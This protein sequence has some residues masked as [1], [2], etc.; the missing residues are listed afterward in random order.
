MINNNNNNNNRSIG[1]ID[2]GIGG[3]SVVKELQ[4]LLPYENIIYF[5]DNKNVPYGN[6]TVGE[7]T[8]LTKRMIDFLISK[9]VK[10]IAIACN[11]I[12]SIIELFSMDYD[13]KI[14]G[15]INPVIDTI[16]KSTD[17]DAVG[18]IA[19]CF[20]V[21]THCYNKALLKV[22]SKINIISEGS[23]ELAE[24][25]DSSDY[26]SE[27]VK[28]V[29]KNH[30]ASILTKENV[31]TIILGCT[32]Y[33]LIMDIFKECYPNINFINPALQ[34]CAELN[35]YLLEN[36][37]INNDKTN[38]SFEIYTTGDIKKYEKGV[39]LLSLKKPDNIIRYIEEN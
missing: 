9:D 15:I 33:P 22:N 11:T 13:I 2:S 29:V 18:L 14:I 3:L 30:I 36:N 25:I 17:K 10:V 32:H 19:T 8:S 39:D 35:Q 6:K 24:I 12:S 37:I 27:D 7:I 26:K 28:F 5:G 20:T 4:L 23:A 34:Q 16:S 21:N 31:D 1:V 38:G